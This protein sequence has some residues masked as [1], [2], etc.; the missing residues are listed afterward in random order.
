MIGLG[1][2]A[3]QFLSRMNSGEEAEGNPNPAIASC[4][5]ATFLAIV[6]KQKKGSTGG[7]DGVVAEFVQVLPVE[8]KSRLYQLL[9][10][11]L[12]G[13]LEPPEH[14]KQAAVSLIP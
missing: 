10:D 5:F 12:A 14:W 11:V 13:Y 7:E 8:S 2:A 1:K 6:S 9:H 3:A 4:S